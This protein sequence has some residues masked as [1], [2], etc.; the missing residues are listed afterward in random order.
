MVDPWVSL[1][2]PEN[3][4][5][6][7]GQQGIRVVIE[8]PVKGPKPGS[9]AWSRLW[10]EQKGRLSNPFSDLNKAVDLLLAGMEEIVARQQGRPVRRQAVL[11]PLSE[12][13][14]DQLVARY[15]AGA[16]VRELVEEFGVHRVTVLQHLEKRG[17][18]RRANSRKM[19]DEQAQE[20]K[21]MWEIGI[22]YRELGR[23]F[24]VSAD[25]VKREIHA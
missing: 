13:A 21:A 18:P 12:T 8:S 14:V 15:Q 16:S 19:T 25:T 6:T 2:N 1:S 20:A 11:R 10:L 3:E 23:K 7:A 24:G 5:E 17:I 9:E 4:Q 22:S